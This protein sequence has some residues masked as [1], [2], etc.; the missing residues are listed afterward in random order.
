MLIWDKVMCIIIIA[1]NSINLVGSPI[2][3]TTILVFPMVS[4]ISYQAIRLKQGIT[5]FEIE[6][7]QDKMK[8]WFY[9]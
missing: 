8:H 4:I 5:P 2:Y 3:F 6:A 9:K 1:L 7:E